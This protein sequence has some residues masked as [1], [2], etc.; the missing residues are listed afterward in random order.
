MR[1]D[2]FHGSGGDDDTRSPGARDRDRILYSRALHRLAGVTQVLS[3]LASGAVH[4][5]LTHSLK[6][7]QIGR[8]LSE[9]LVRSAAADE[10]LAGAIAALGGLDPE[11]AEAGGLAHDIGHPPFGH[12]GE[13][14]LDALLLD[15][16]D[17]EGFNG[18]AQAFR[19]LTADDHDRPEPG[20]D[21]TRATLRANLKYPWFRGHGADGPDDPR[22]NAWGAYSSEAD[23]FAFA[24]A[25][26]PAEGRSLEAEIVDWADDISYAVHDVED[27]TAGG[28]IPLL[29]LEADPDERER[30]LALAD[31]GPVS[32][33]D[34]AHGL[35]VVL[36]FSRARPS[37]LNR[38]PVFRAGGAMLDFLVGELVVRSDGPGGAPCAAPTPVAAAATRVLKELTAVYVLEEPALG[39]VHDLQAEVV[40][41]L[42][43]VL[44]KQGASPRVAGDSIAALDDRE[45]LQRHAAL[46]GPDLAGHI[47]T[48]TTLPPTDGGEQPPA[49]ATALAAGRAAGGR[50][51][52]PRS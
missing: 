47:A 25:G 3:P 10:E 13:R 28:A 33:A 24:C 27:F 40:T 22:W 2:R 34:L 5:R 35:D 43:E 44:L 18:N 52:A 15:A 46:F 30:F 31:P 20:L 36:D 45:A 42:F 48:L 32:P 41:D 11:V 37:T 19:V 50:P 14:T 23:A 29:A 51:A 17:D 16:G 8:R 38:W 9:S 39:R 4:N 6:V 7:A 49:L 1:D 12:L 21:L 26:P